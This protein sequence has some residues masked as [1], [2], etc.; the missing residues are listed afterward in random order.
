MRISASRANILEKQ[1]TS[2]IA[3]T[4]VLCCVTRVRAAN[5]IVM[6]DS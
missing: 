6:Y 3:R 1:D 5:K 2:S 4:V